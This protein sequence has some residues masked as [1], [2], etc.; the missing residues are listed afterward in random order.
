LELRDKELDRLKNDLFELRNKNRRQN[1]IEK[2]SIRFMETVRKLQAKASPDAARLQFLIDAIDVCFDI[3]GAVAFARKDGA[4]A[5]DEP[6]EFALAGRFG[7]SDEPP[8]KIFAEG[9]GI[10]GQVV[11]S[12]KTVTLEKVPADYLTAL[13]G[14]GRSRDINVYVLPLSDEEGDVRAVIEVA[15]FEK[16][17]IVDAWENI[18]TQLRDVIQSCR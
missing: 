15:S 4:T 7:L 6:A 3:T 16:L 18:E 17:K 11:A 8:T 1:A 5:E 2:G 13:S 12:D 9:D 10:L 14:L